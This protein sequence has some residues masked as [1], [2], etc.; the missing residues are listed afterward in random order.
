MQVTKIAW[1]NPGMMSLAPV[2]T[3]LG[4]T[5]KKINFEN[6]QKN[7]GFNQMKDFLW[8]LAQCNIKIY[9]GPKKIFFWGGG[10]Y[11]TL[12]LTNMLHLLQGHSCF[13]RIHFYPKTK[14][15]KNNKKSNPDHH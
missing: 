11:G 4:G 7:Q 9:S 1:E 15:D 5:G 2:F 10:G 8:N 6:S 12:K 3:S 13:F 14:K